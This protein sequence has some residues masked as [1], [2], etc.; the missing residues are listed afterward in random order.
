MRDRVAARAA[1]VLHRAQVQDLGPARRHLEHL[2]IGNLT[3]FFRVENDAR[4]ACEHAIDVGENLA[5]IGVE[6]A[7]EGDPGEALV[8][9]EDRHCHHLHTLEYGPTIR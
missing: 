1:R 9:V 8:D 5:G 3:N 6:G 7:G 4:I 2:V